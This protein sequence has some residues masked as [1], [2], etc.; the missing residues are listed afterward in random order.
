VIAVIGID[1]VLGTGI[2]VSVFAAGLV[3][4]LAAART[5]AEALAARMTENL[6]RA[7]ARLRFIF[8][9]APVG[10]SWSVAGDASSTAVNPEHVRLTGISA[11]DSRKPGVFAAVT[12][13]DDYR[14]QDE[15]SKKMVRGETD[16]FS[17]EKRYLHPDGRVPHSYDV[18]GVQM[19]RM[20]VSG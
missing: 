5:P 20:S 12:H 19:W 16:P 11:D 13:P 6:R 3:W 7:E 10:I 4:A 17:L 2:A 8:E 18:S 15:L 14:R 9:C 1:K